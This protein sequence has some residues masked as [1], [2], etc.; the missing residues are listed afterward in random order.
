MIDILATVN[1]GGNRMSSADEFSGGPAG[2]PVTDYPVRFTVDYED[3][4]RNR[5]TT[6]FR[7]ILVIPIGIVFALV[8]GGVGLARANETTSTIGHDTVTVFV[9]GG[10]LLVAAPL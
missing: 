4:P 5:L 1:G 9:G 6:L 7:I 8:D 10:G 3:Q 2:G